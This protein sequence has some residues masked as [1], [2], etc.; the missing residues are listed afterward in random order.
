MKFIFS[1]IFLVFSMICVAAQDDQTQI[2]NR[3]KPVG[4][5]TVAEATDTTSTKPAE[6]KTANSGETIYKKYCSLCHSI[7][8]GGAPRFHSKD[9]WKERMKQGID[10]LVKNAVN[11]IRAM[12]AKGTCMTCSEAELK[13]AIEHMLPK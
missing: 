1:I 5:V 10:T 12:P 11:G 2:A 13:N 7:G 4:Q 8:V 6:V 9:D 3:I